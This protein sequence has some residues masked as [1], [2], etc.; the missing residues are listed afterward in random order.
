MRPSTPPGRRPGH[1]PSTVS[2]PPSI[3]LGR[4]EGL[5]TVDELTVRHVTETSRRLMERSSTIATA[6]ADGDTAIVGLT[7]QL[8][9]GNM[10]VHTAIGRHH[11]RP[12]WCCVGG[13][14]MLPTLRSVVRE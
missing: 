7:Y 11:R 10:Q 6:V 13:W 14:V 3:L 2:P 9:D 1:G 4:S 8:A 12:G 5:S